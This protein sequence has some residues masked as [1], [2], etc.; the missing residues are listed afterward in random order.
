MRVLSMSLAY[1]LQR[2]LSLEDGELLGSNQDTVE[3]SCLI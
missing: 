2:E 3:F 1:D